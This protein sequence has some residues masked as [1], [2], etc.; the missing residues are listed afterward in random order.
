[1]TESTEQ[2]DQLPDALIERLKEQDRQISMLTTAI[3]SLL[4]VIG[5]ADGVHLLAAYRAYLSETGDFRQSVRLM[6]AARMASSTSWV[7]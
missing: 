5:I 6:I 1:M 3:P 2:F 4:L 7:R